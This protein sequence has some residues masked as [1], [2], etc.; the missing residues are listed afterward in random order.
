MRLGGRWQVVERVVAFLNRCKIQ[1]AGLLI[2]IADDRGVGVR[3]HVAFALAVATLTCVLL[4]HSFAHLVIMVN[5]QHTA[6]VGT[7]ERVLEVFGDLFLVE[8]LLNTV[9]NCHD[10]FD[11]LVKDV[12]FL[13]TLKCNLTL[14]VWNS[15]LGFNN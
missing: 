10:S 11:V 4:C 3:H 15:F 6:L 9:D 5:F 8:L 7:M 14:F 12:A 13:K 1:I 2:Q